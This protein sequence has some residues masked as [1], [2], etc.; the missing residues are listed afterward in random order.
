MRMADFLQFCVKTLCM[1]FI[2]GAKLQLRDCR[3]QLSFSASIPGEFSCHLCMDVVTGA[4]RSPVVVKPEAA[5][6]LL[7]RN[8]NHGNASFYSNGRNLYTDLMRKAINM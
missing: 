3:Q 1:M 6:G 5:V 8:C 7:W 2:M 4:Y